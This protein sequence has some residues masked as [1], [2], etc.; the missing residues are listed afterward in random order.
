MHGLFTPSA[1]FF[2]NTTTLKKI[3]PSRAKTRMGTVPDSR[4]LNPFVSFEERN[5]V[6]VSVSDY[7]P[8]LG[9]WP[10]CLV[11]VYHTVVHSCPFENLQ[12]TCL[13]LLT[14]TTGILL[15]RRLLREPYEHDLGAAQ[16]AP[17]ICGVLKGTRARRFQHIKPE[18]GHSLVERRP[19]RR[20]NCKR[21]LGQPG[22]IRRAWQRAEGYVSRGSCIWLGN[23]AEIMAQ[24]HTDEHMATSSKD[25]SFHF[26]PL[27]KVFGV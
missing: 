10:V 3:A 26:R 12:T 11:A 4:T 9:A 27:F 19:K 5:V 13:P 25:S 24:K 21:L 2:R 14:C 6:K 20:R 1:V 23:A 15:C 8:T 18:R 17:S 7:T 16:H 22:S